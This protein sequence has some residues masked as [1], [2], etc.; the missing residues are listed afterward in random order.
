MQA[1]GVAGQVRWVLGCQA[2]ERTVR[3]TVIVRRGEGR[4]EEHQGENY[5]VLSGK[6]E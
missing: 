5:A 6:G 3:G 4:P 2:E 1:G